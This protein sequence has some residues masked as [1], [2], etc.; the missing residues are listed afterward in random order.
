MSG[1]KFLPINI[2]KATVI[3]VALKYEEKQLKFNAEVALI[4]EYGKRI[5]SVYVGN[6]NWN[7]ENAELTLLCIDL[8]KKIRAE[9]EDSVTKFM[10]AQ[11]KIIDYKKD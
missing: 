4:N 8:A 3:S 11:Q 6:D 1:K 2:T 9:I 5:T 10:N 7:G